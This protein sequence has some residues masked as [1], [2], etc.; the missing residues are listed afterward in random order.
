MPFNCPEFVIQYD[1][2]V[3]TSCALSIPKVCKY[4]YTKNPPY[5]C[6]KEKHAQVI[7]VLSTAFANAGAFRSLWLIFVIFFLGKLFPEGFE[8]Y[9]KDKFHRI[10]LQMADKAAHLHDNF[11][12]TLHHQRE[13][14]EEGMHRAK[15]AFNHLTDTQPDST[16]NEGYTTVPIADTG[17]TPDVAVNATLHFHR[18]TNNLNKV[19]IAPL[20]I[21]LADTV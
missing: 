8:D 11:V 20:D 18:P 15:E 13:H 14:L 1:N 12:D 7:T 3:A 5:Y 4:E 17:I 16:A 10:H 21:Q 9:F 19:F 2:I 6:T